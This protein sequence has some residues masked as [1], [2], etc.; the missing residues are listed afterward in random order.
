M[1]MNN[2]L[3]PRVNRIL[4][5]LEKREEVKEDDFMYSYF[6]ELMMENSVS[7]EKIK[8]VIIREFGYSDEANNLYDDLI[9]ILTLNN[10]KFKN[11]EKELLEEI[12]DLKSKIN[13]Q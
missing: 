7:K 12:E 3:S 13:Q 11:R 2:E 10:Y 8:E 5:R 4:E 6:L 1:K 9:S